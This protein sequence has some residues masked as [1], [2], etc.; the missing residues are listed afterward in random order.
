MFDEYEISGFIL[1]IIVMAACYA[2]SV[3]LQIHIRDVVLG[4]ILLALIQQDMRDSS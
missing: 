3:M 1:F 2:A 4:T